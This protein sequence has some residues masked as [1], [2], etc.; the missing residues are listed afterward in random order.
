[1]TL[2]CVICSNPVLYRGKDL[3]KK[4]VQA[5]RGYCSEEHKLE[6]IRQ[7][8]VRAGESL[9][10]YNRTY[11]SERMRKHNPMR[12]PKARAKMVASLKGRTFLSRG[13]NG[14]PTKPQL[15]LAKALG[16]PI[17]VPIR[18]K[19]V[20]HLFASLP[21]C[22]KVDIGNQKIKLAIEVDGQSHRLKKWRFLDR[23]K[24]EVLASLGWTVL[25]FWNEDVME[26]LEDCVRM[27]SCTTSKLKA[28]TRTSRTA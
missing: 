26:R 16:L 24:E 10:I 7:L 22:Y 11:A 20:R 21:K 27:V 9:A 28:R 4:N 19:S 5:G 13:G 17:E 23:R 12:N 8:H 1:M 3:Q 6:F 14:T 2:P 25:R 15:R 18:V